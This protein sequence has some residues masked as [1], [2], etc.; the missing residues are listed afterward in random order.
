MFY[1]ILI[2]EV[3]C[4]GDG[5]MSYNGLR[6]SEVHR[7]WIWAKCRRHEARYTLLGDSANE[8]VLFLNLINLKK[9]GS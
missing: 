7:R 8:G 2:A 4:Q 6:V 1:K 3:T 9:S 5:K